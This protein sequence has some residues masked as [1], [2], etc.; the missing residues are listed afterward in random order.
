M[1]VGNFKCS[2]CGKRFKTLV[3]GPEKAISCPSC[4][5]EQ[6]EQLDGKKTFLNSEDPIEILVASEPDRKGYV[7]KSYKYDDDTLSGKP[8]EGG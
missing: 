6:V 7:V 1:P 8:K 5:S 3:T 2:N 4:K